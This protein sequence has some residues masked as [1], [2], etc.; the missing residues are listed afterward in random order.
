MRDVVRDYVLRET[1]HPNTVSLQDPV[2]TREGEELTL[3]DLLPG[4][5]DPSDVAAQ[6]ELEALGR[7]HAEE[8]LA[9]LNRRE[10]VALAAKMAG[11]SLAHRAV[12]QAAGCRKTALN[13]AYRKFVA[14]TVHTLA[15]RYPG[16]DRESV[17]TL[18]QVTIAEVTRR[19]LDWARA[20]SACAALFSSMEGEPQAA[21]ATAAAA[22]ASG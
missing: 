4:S 9:G 10:R 20:E 2:R 13:A 8:L 6:H 1:P 17:L 5:V 7:R 11:F 15:R 12:E 22:S 14:R 18:A 21:A 19:T 16:E 3:E